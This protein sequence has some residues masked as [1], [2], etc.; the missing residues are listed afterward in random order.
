MNL[1]LFSC[2]TEIQSGYVCSG[3]ETKRGMF[4]DITSPSSSM[5]YILNFNGH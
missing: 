5:N 3:L 2:D 1:G 4:L